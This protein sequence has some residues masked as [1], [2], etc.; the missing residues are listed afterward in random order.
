MLEAMKKGA[1][2]YEATECY[3]E[4]RV[5]NE[6]AIKLIRGPR[7]RQVEEKLWILPRR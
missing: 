3:L 4:V 7:F 6:P 2:F 1:T 5:G